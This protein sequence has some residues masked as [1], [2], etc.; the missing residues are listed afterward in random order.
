MCL[1]QAGSLGRVDLGSGRLAELYPRSCLGWT[2]C[3]DLGVCSVGVAVVPGYNRLPK[4]RERVQCEG[5]QRG[6]KHPHSH[7]QPVLL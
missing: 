2:P 6:R 1:G 7:H 5:G 4:Q 3:S